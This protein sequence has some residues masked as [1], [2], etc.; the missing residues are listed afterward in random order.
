MIL[1]GFDFIF[2]RLSSEMIFFIC[3]NHIRIFQYDGRET[4]KWSNNIAKTYVSV[5]SVSWVDIYSIF[6]MARGSKSLKLIMVQIFFMFRAD[7]SF[8]Q[9]RQDFYLTIRNSR[10]INEIT[11]IIGLFSC[12]HSFTNRKWILN[13]WWNAEKLHNY[14]DFHY[15]MKMLIWS[16]SFWH[17]CSV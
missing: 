11:M 16:V 10:K 1:I 4:L 5:P 13:S 9:S 7:Y 14:S 15:G 6:A 17:L 12:I 8:N 2:T 3:D